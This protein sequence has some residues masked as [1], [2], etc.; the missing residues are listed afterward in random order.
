[1]CMPRVIGTSK[2]IFKTNRE[3]STDLESE[4]YI[5]SA[6]H[7]LHATYKIVDPLDPNDNSIAHQLAN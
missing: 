1:M 6:I 3:N 7:P 4:T 5:G 2:R